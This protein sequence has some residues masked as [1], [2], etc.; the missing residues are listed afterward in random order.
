MD[1]W[2]RHSQTRVESPGNRAERLHVSI[3]K[4]KLKGC[5]AQCGY[6]WEMYPSPLMAEI[7]FHWHY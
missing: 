2:L 6:I 7:V 1:G 5:I 4:E 3:M